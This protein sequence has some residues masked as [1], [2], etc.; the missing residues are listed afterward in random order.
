V[1]RDKSK[2]NYSSSSTGFNPRARVGR[3]VCGRVR[4]LY[5]RCFNPR[6]RVGRDVSISFIA[7]LLIQFQSTRPR[8]AR[9]A[10]YK[11]II[12]AVV[13]Q[14]TRPRGARPKLFTKSV[15]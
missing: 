10:E 11:N 5:V 4:M 15:M 8:G 12:N 7:L 9:H 6:A 3:D 14:S 2:Y 13:F 1:G